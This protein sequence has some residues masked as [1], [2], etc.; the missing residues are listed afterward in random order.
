MAGLA[1]VNPV[2]AYLSGGTICSLPV[3]P[4]WYRLALSWI[5][6][7]LILLTVIGLY[8]AIYL[9]VHYKFK[10]IDTETSDAKHSSNEFSRHS[11]QPGNPTTLPT[12]T[13]PKIVM[14]RPTSLARHGLIPSDETGLSNQTDRLST[15][16]KPV[17]DKYDFGGSQP[18][19]P[20]PES[21]DTLLLPPEGRP[22]SSRTIS[23][24]VFREPST[25]SEEPRSNY[26]LLHALR[27]SRIKSFAPTSESESTAV[28]TVDGADTAPENGTANGN[29]KPENG[30]GNVVSRSLRRRHRAI[31]QKLRLL[32]IYPIVYL[33]MYMI[34][35]SQ[36]CLQYSDY[37]SQ[38]PPFPLSVCSVACLA[39][40]GTI[41]SIVFTIREKPWRYVGKG[42]F[43]PWSKPR[44]E[45]IR[46]RRYS[47]SGIEGSLIEGPD[48][49]VQR[50]LST[51]RVPS[52][53][54]SRESV[55]STRK[56]FGGSAS[57]RNSNESVMS[58]KKGLVKE[59]NWWEMEGRIRMDS[60]L[61]G[62]DHDHAEHAWP[63]R[64][65]SAQLG[66]PVIK[67]EEESGQPSTPGD[68]GG[69]SEG[70]GSAR[71][72]YGGL[73]GGR[74]VPAVVGRSSAG[75][76]G[77]RHSYGFTESRRPSAA[78]TPDRRS[79]VTSGPEEIELTDVKKD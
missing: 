19:S 15:G 51:R 23:D 8:I 38:N 60:V 76:E 52:V 5:P 49:N 79:S 59:K 10:G 62:T 7:Y 34:P 54:N 75:N 14:R 72:G 21:Q 68:T 12:G 43:F 45:F 20:L 1:F 41:D 30:N 13:I 69:Q 18:V 64:R 17:W 71:R 33:L 31:K 70:L 63:G 27:D 36:H 55:I 42:R 58:A 39:L 4:F 57:L 11:I 74:T 44:E 66:G 46:H 24:D 22:G 61:L 78:E 3:R 26:F 32:F 77:R 56:G 6:R 28:A 9:Y 48:G 25:N 29:S 67:E 53:K 65:G 47:G 16:E 50:A 37:Y 73:H 2:D 35:F 40:Q